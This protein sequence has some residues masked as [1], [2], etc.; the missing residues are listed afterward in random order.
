ML[1]IIIILCVLIIFFFIG[2][3]LY[4]II[5]LPKDGW[6]RKL[7]DEEQMQALKEYYYGKD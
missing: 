6:E 2:M 1:K 7:E 3:F 4:S 5:Q